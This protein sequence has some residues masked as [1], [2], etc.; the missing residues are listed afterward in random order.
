MGGVFTADMSRAIRVAEALEAGQVYLNSYGA[1]GG[2]GLPFGGVKKSGFGR[3]KGV[4][5][6]YEYTQA[7]TVVVNVG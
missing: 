7:K 4:E 1:A 6:V 2:I 3:E 5:A